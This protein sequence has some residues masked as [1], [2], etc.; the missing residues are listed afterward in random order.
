MSATEGFN[1]TNQLFTGAFSAGDAE[2]VAGFY[3]VHRRF[4]LTKK[5]L[6]LYKTRAS[7]PS[8]LPTHEL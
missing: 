8:K 3:T 2:K 7:L 5:V 6:R 1:E 4:Y